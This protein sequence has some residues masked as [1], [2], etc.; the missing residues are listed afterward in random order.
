[1]DPFA[2]TCDPR[3]YVPRPASE[4]ALA[5]LEGALVRHRVCALSGPP[6]IGK[7]LL[8]R[9]LEA[10]V[11]GRARCVYVPYGAL[12]ASDLCRLVL[13]LMS[14]S[15]PPETDPEQMLA[16]AARLEA[17]A[18]RPLLLLLDDAHAIPQPTVRRLVALA[19]LLGGALRLLAVPVDDARAARVLAAL[20]AD[21]GHVRFVSPMSE[22]ETDRY[23]AARVA[24]VGAPPDTVARITPQALR[25]LHRESA[26]IPRRLHQLVGW[27]LHRDDPAPDATPSLADGGPALELDPA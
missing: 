14:R 24:R 3:A 8:L 25:W 22:E 13:G 11:A 21:V 17:S 1:M 19:A 5:A 10:R 7:T 6:G 23:V 16:E 27:M 9:V 18:G 2:L 20:G 26:G 4:A 12:E 15:V